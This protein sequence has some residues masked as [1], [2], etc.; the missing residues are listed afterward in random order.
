M[1]S[2]LLLKRIDIKQ[3]NS[4]QLVDKQTKQ[5]EIRVDDDTIDASF[6]VVTVVML[7]EPCNTDNLTNKDTAHDDKYFV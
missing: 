4:K 6:F 7:C 5:C 2:V 3:Q 1:W